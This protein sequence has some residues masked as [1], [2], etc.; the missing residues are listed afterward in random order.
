MVVLFSAVAFL[1]TLAGGL[2]AMWVRDHRHLVL[3]LAGGL[4]LGVVTDR[5]PKTK[6]TRQQSGDRPI[7]GRAA[8]SRRFRA[9]DMQSGRGSPLPCASR[10]VVLSL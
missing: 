4:M 8:A 5:T 6:D 1:T 10:V 9:L 3:G 7:P 2:A